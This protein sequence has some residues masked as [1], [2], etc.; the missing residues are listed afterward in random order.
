M[1]AG[2]SQHRITDTQNHVGPRATA[3]ALAALVAEAEMRRAA[4]AMN[5]TLP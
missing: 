1:R 5:A 3:K 4:Y 2:L